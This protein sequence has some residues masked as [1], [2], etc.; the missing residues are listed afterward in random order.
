[1]RNT[2]HPFPNQAN[3]SLPAP[4]LGLRCARSPCQSTGILAVR[5]LLYN[6]RSFNFLGGCSKDTASNTGHR[7]RQAF[8]VCSHPGPDG[9]SESAAVFWR[10][11]EAVGKLSWG[12]S[13]VF[14]QIL[15][16]VRPY[17]HTIMNVS[18]PLTRPRLWYNRFCVGV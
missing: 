18:K 13:L 17:L 11:S 14:P 3:L 6:T 16:K 2:E 1:M 4:P 10:L 15:Q 7:K 5:S 9:G 8:L 12:K